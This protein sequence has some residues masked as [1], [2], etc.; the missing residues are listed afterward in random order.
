[1]NKITEYIQESYSELINKVSW[2]SWAELQESAIIVFSSSIIIAMFVFLMD[3][4]VGVRPEGS[5]WSGLL[6]L[7]YSL[8]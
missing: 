7:I 3:F 4:I 1:M 8:F 5:T 2:P 6:G